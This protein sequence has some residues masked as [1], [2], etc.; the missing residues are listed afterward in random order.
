MD[1]NSPKNG[2]SQLIVLSK[3]HN[4]TVDNIKIIE[5]DQS[6]NCSLQDRDPRRRHSNPDSVQSHDR[7]S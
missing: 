1:D 2:G 4:I 6:Y 5:H 3:R 7:E